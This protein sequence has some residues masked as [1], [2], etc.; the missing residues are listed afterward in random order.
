MLCSYGFDHI[1][2]QYGEGIL[3]SINGY[4]SKA[5][6]AMNVRLDQHSL[7]DASAQW[8]TCCRLLRKQVTCVPEIMAKIASLPLM[9]RSFNVEPIVAPTPKSGKDLSLTQTGRQ[10]QAYLEHWCGHGSMPLRM[11]PRP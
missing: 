8:R 7:P 1:D 3:S 9:I 10:Y 5:S 6:D 2:V 11:V 4:V